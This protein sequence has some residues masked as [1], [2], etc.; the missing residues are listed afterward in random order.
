MSRAGVARAQH[1][2]QRR[3]LTMGLLLVLTFIPHV[4]MKGAMAGG[5]TLASRRVVETLRAGSAASMSSNA[6]RMRSAFFGSIHARAV[7]SSRSS[8]RIRDIAQVRLRRWC[9]VAKISE[10]VRASPVGVTRR[11]DRQLPYG[12][13]VQSFQSGPAGERSIRERRIAASLSAR[14]KNLTF[15][16]VSCECY[17]T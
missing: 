14:R 10:A 12:P 6:S 15:G 2:A 11:K 4:K 1:Q 7:F 5:H 16:G 17:L 9:R 8:W 3:P 13:N